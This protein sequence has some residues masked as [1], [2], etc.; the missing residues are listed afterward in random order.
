[1]MQPLVEMQGK[2]A[3]IRP[4]VV[5]PIPGPCTNGSYVHQ[6]AFIVSDDVQ[7]PYIFASLVM[8]GLTKNY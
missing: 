4:K 1:M 8:V 2:V 3:Y 7:L 6:V 5:G